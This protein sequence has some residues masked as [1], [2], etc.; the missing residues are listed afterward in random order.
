MKRRFDQTFNQTVHDSE[1]LEETL[2]NKTARTDDHRNDLV[3]QFQP[4]NVMNTMNVT[5]T[6]PGTIEDSIH[7]KNI[8]TK[9]EQGAAISQH[10]QASH[11]LQVTG[12][13][14]DGT[15][16]MDEPAEEQALN[17]NPIVS[18]SAHSNPKG[19]TDTSTSKMST[20]NHDSDSTSRSTKESSVVNGL[21]DDNL[22]LD[23]I[24]DWDAFED[25]FRHISEESNSSSSAAN[26]HN[27][28][29]TA[30]SRPENSKPK[31]QPTAKP[32][33]RREHVKSSGSSSSSLGSPSAA[34]T[35]QSNTAANTGSVRVTSSS[36]YQTNFVGT[37]QMRS[38]MQVP[39]PMMPGQ[40]NLRS[41]LAQHLH[42]NKQLGNHYA[43][44]TSLPGPE[45]PQR[46]RAHLAQLQEHVRRRQLQQQQQMQRRQHME[47]VRQQISQQM[48]QPYQQE[49]MRMAQAAQH[50]QRLAAPQTMSPISPHLQQSFP[51]QPLPSPMSS[52]MPHTPQINSSQNPFQFPN[53]FNSYMN[54]KQ[55]QGFDGMGNIQAPPDGNSQM[56]A[57]F[58]SLQQQ[59]HSPFSPGKPLTPNSP[60][61]SNPQGP[62]FR[63]ILARER[64]RAS[65]MMPPPQPMQNPMQGPQGTFD[66]P[67]TRPPPQ[68]AASNFQPVSTPLDSQ[69]IQ[70]SLSVGQRNTNR[71]SHFNATHPDELSMKA[72][73]GLSMYG[74][75]D[76]LYSPLNGPN[77]SVS[78]IPSGQLT[79]NLSTNASSYPPPN[80]NANN[81]VNM[82]RTSNISPSGSWGNDLQMSKQQVLQQRLNNLQP[83][84]G[85]VSKGPSLNAHVR[86][87]INHE[88]PLPTPYSS[89]GQSIPNMTQMSN[90]SIPTSYRTSLSKQTLGIPKTEMPMPDTLGMP[91]RSNDSEDIESLLSNPPENFDL[92]QMLGP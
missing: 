85:P 67:G 19:S 5:K 31:E 89:Q 35:F 7:Q 79:D 9:V 43:G 71:L 80:M 51:Q 38:Q 10:E 91:Q 26:N 18:S 61:P 84:F 20:A 36:P 17:N 59:D 37:A 63:A 1:D 3:T 39:A 12:D 88:R 41:Y 11:I 78:T 82:A 86:Q 46:T 21:V 74:G 77:P 49:L 42:Q 28:V 16:G 50:Q 23:I 73:G 6:D 75:G 53:D 54:H 40:A 14:I 44:H 48:Q 83:D 66:G 8:S 27:N 72:S 76:N 55:I 87:N 62:S 4:T 47:M 52:P 92:V 45:M 58:Y 29:R 24:K 32:R 56:P 90:S 2:G 68:Y 64:M 22:P 70:N 81:I 34:H 57:N 65:N 60:H 13:S 25:V 15:I 33:E 30:Q 69:Q